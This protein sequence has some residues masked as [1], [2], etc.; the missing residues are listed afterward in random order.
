MRARIVVLAVMA[1]FACAGQVFH[2]EE[3]ALRI[4]LKECSS[5]SREEKTLQADERARLQAE[6]GLRF[7]QPRYVVYRCPAPDG[8]GRFAVILEEIG[9]SE[10]ITFMTGVDGSGRAGA[11]VLMIFRESRGSEVKDQRFMGQFRGKTPADPVRVNRDIVNVAG[12]SLSSEAIARGVKKALAL[13]NDCY[14][15]R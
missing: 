10:P 15:K 12:A 3:S 8:T 5:P 1:S 13:V 2:T 7:A 11:V 4:V 9:K 6:T 14:L